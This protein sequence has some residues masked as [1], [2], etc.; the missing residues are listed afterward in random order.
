VLPESIKDEINLIINHQH[1]YEKISKWNIKTSMLYKTQTIKAI[2]HGDSGTGK[3]LCARYIASALNKDMFQACP[4]AIFQRWVGESE[5]FARKLFT[6]YKKIL[7]IDPDNAPILFI[8]EADSLF[9]RR[10]AVNQKSDF[11]LNTVI[12]IFLE[13]L[14]ACKGIVL[15]CT[16]LM[17]ENHI[18]SAFL[19]RFNFKIKFELPNP[20]ERVRIFQSHL[21]NAPLSPEINL[22]K[23]CAKYTFSGG[24]I[25]K[26]TERC[27]LLAA[28]EDSN[29]IK[30]KHIIKA[31]ESE[32]NC[33]NRSGYKKKLWG[34][35]KIKIINFSQIMKNYFM[36]HL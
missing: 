12:N 33:L 29:M 27:V 3:T 10:V 23:I 15:C 9:A 4:D 6:D 5:K 18:D 19:R 1:Y 25:A 21:G 11:T 8:D 14:E 7:E 36:P 31:F 2:F 17:N 26:I 16:N 30:E 20:A 28:V 34:L 24:Q 13:E 32:L 22:E 35:L